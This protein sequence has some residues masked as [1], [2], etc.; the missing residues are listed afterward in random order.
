M[1]INGSVSWVVKDLESIDNVEVW[2]VSKLDL[3]VLDFLFEIA[4][5]LEG[6]NEFILLVKWKNWLSRWGNMVGHSFDDSHWGGGS[7]WGRFSHWGGTS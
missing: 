3:G 1:D 7:S 2:L 4:N 5:L 6:M